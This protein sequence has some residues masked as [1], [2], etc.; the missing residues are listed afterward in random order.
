MWHLHVCVMFH[1]GL[2]VTLS[3]LGTV[4]DVTF[5]DII[6]DDLLVDYVDD[7]SVDDYYEHQ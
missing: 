3:F 6:S 2:R 1:I 7:T 5:Y 4:D